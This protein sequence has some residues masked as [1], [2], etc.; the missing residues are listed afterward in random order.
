MNVSL[1]IAGDTCPSHAYNELHDL[2]RVGLAAHDGARIVADGAD[3]VHLFGSYDRA[4]L[5]LLSWYRRHMIPTVLTI[6]DGLSAFTHYERDPHAP[7]RGLK[8]HILRKATAVH[9][10]GNEEKDFI[11]SI[12]DTIKTAVIKNPIVTSQCT[13]DGTI[14]Q[15]MSLYTSA[16]AAN[17]KIVDEYIEG[18]IKKSEATEPELKSILY[19]LLHSRYL[20]NRNLL[21]DERLTKLSR[22]LTDTV[23]NE[24]KLAVCLK[25]LRIDDYTA[26]LLT[27]L[28]SKTMLTEGFM[29]IEPSRN[30]LKQ[31][32]MSMPKSKDTKTDQ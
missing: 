10:M 19:A 18:I 8:S 27:L 15:F 28:E 21:S 12:S 2:L 20:N 30:P 7:K 29:P 5:R 22:K 25:S 14:R 11:S 23:Y 17:D 32:P 16:I 13:V 1:I 3:I 4:T 9:A 6:C 24:D 26:R 31:N